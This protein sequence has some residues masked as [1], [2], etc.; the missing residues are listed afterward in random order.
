MGV[1][2]FEDFPSEETEEINKIEKYSNNTSTLADRK[3]LGSIVD[4][5]IGS[6]ASPTLIDNN[7]KKPT[8]PIGYPNKGLNATNKLVVGDTPITN[9]KHAKSVLTTGGMH[10]WERILRVTLLLRVK[11]LP[12]ECV[13]ANVL[14]MKKNFI[15]IISSEYVV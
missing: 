3:D 9:E 4:E 11:F 10:F 1:L 12:K 5:L 8:S 2:S 7:F 13:K 15:S 6:I 14:Y